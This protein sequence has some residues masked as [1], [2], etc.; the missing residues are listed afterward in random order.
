MKIQTPRKVAE[1]FDKADYGSQRGVLQTASSP[2]E[3]ES[4]CRYPHSQ[5]CIVCGYLQRIGV[6]AINEAM[7]RLAQ[8]GRDRKTSL[9]ELLT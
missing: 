6:R 1:I 9:G 3:R 7:T 2:E 4:Y 5:L 8:I